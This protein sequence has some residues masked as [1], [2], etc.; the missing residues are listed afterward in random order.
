M[1]IIALH[2]IWRQWNYYEVAEILL[3]HGADIDSCNEKGRTPLHMACD[4]DI[5][6]ET[7]VA[8]LLLERGANVNAPDNNLDTPLLMAVRELHVEVAQILL[9]NGAEPNV[10]NKDGKTSLHLFPAY[11]GNRYYIESKRLRFAS[12]VLQRGTDV[13]AQDKYHATPLHVTMKQGLNKMAQI[14]LEHGAEPNAAN[15]Y[16]QTPLHL[17]FQFEPQF[18]GE[19]DAEIIIAGATHLLLQCGA[20]VNAHDRDHKTPLHLAIQRNVY[21]IARVL[22]SRG[23]KPNVKNIGGKT[24][25]HLLLE[26]NFKFAGDEGDIPG[27]VRLLLERGADVNAQDQNHT[28]PLSLAMARHLVHIARILLQHGAEPNIKNIKGKTPLHV[29][30][31]QDFDF[32]GTVDVDGISGVVRLLLDSGADV[33]A[34]DEDNITPMHLAFRWPHRR[35]Y[36]MMW[37]I[38]LRRANPE[39]YRH[40]AQ[41]PIAHISHITSEGEYNF[42]EQRP[43]VSQ[44]SLERTPDANVQN[45]DLITRLHWACNLGRLE[46]AREL[47]DNGVNANVENIRGETPLHLVSRGQY[48]TQDR[49]VGVVQLLLE[50]GANVDAQDKSHITPLHLASYYGKLEIVRLLLHHGA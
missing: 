39:T 6:L 48:D 18:H 33:N 30:L 3:E 42:N 13:N 9:E 12:L 20:D 47:L 25:L 38:L 43:G 11:D 5:G 49:G 2:C 26:G 50:R 21:D 45:M 4:G 46:M 1:G 27:L 28:S 24:P 35:Y 31:E 15:K 44:F 8:R 32:Y 23:A 37:Q 10:K 19:S 40:R 29:L 41:I 22:L 34:Q 36:E 7:D 16:G 14:L 17:A